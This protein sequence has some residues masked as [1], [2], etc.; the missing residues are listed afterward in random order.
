MRKAAGHPRLRRRPAVLLQ[1]VLVF[2]VCGKAR[3]REPQDL[4]GL[5]GVFQRV[6]VLELALHDVGARGNDALDRF[7]RGLDLLLGAAQRR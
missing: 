2:L 5:V 1:L 7:A 4:I 6:D 3:G